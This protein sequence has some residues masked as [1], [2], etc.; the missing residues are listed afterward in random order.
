MGDNNRGNVNAIDCASTTATVL[1]ATCYRPDVADPLALSSD[2]P[3]NSWL[4]AT[5]RLRLN[6]RSAWC[7]ALDWGWA[8]RL[9]AG[10]WR[11]AWNA[12]Q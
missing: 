3:W 6:E 10:I 5:W 9:L 1:S 11:V 8:V 4:P 12:R 2:Q 7:R